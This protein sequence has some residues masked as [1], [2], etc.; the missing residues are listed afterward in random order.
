MHS[1]SISCFIL[2]RYSLAFTFGGLLQRDLNDFKIE[3]NSHPIRKN[4]R[5]QTVHGC[6]DDIYDMPALHGKK[7]YLE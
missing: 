5:Q 2:A 4:R 1:Y 3:W 7:H 6:P